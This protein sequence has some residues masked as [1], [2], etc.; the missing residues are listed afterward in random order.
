MFT[1]NIFRMTDTPIVLGLLLVFIT[2]SAKELIASATN[3]P[4]IEYH[5]RWM[6]ESE[7]RKWSQKMRASALSCV[8]RSAVNGNDLNYL[9]V[10][11]QNL[12]DTKLLKGVSVSF[13]YPPG[14]G[15][16][17]SGSRLLSKAPA[18]KGDVLEMCSNNGFE[19]R[20]LDFHPHWEHTAI[21][22]VKGTSQPFAVLQKSEVAT[23]F[24]QRNLKTTLVRNEVLITLI[25]L[26][27]A[28]VIAL[29]YFMSLS[30]ARTE[31]NCDD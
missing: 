24:E 29:F 28:I 31:A 27:L 16:T 20:G 23:L 21:L 25:S 1:N 6:D 5:Y 17:I 13:V 26:G 18:I 30:S 22:A 7:Y 11:M 19:I 8:D 3:T 2:W 14:S 4:L 9:L 12:S 10:S 15:S